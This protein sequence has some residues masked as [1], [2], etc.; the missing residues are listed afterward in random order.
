MMKRSLV[1]LGAMM[2]VMG[3]SG[4]AIA[5]DEA[6]A[7]GKQL[8]LAN[9]CNSC[10][11][12]ASQGVEKK[13]AAEAEEAKETK[14]PA[15]EA[16]EGAAT[17][18]KK[19]PDLGGVGVERKADWIVKYLSKLE[20]I[21]GKKHMKK[22]RGTDDELKTLAAWLESL[23]DETAGKAMMEMEKPASGDAKAATET[24][25]E[26]TEKKA[27]GTDTKTEGDSK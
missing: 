6:P 1:V 13:S 12:I 3:M 5:A 4:A 16:K 24:K 23:K 25:T 8:F 26:G 9:K 15:A 21:D 17:T 11:T 20:A 27:E 22:F 7:P 2:L 10:H 19:V 14:E 18:S